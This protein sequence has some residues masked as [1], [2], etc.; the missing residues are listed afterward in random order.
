MLLIVNLF[1]LIVYVLTF[2]ISLVIGRV[3]F[4]DTVC[5]LIFVFYCVSKML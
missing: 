3:A 5:F 2:V 1:I 4:I